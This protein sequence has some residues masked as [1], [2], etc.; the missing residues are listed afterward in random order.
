MIVTVKGK[1]FTGF[2]EGKKFTELPWVKR[3]VKEKLGFTPYAGT[4]NIILPPDLQISKLLNEFKGWEI[5]PENGYF[6]GYFHKALINGEIHGAVVRPS[7][8]RYPRDVVE[9]LAPICLRERFNLKDGDEVEVKI[10][11]E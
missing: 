10:W 9:I 5:P 2:S 3:R 7:I 11:L 6:P 8:P 1:V 4:L